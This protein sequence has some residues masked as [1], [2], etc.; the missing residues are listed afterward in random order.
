MFI[1]GYAYQLGHV[2]IG[3]EAIEQAIELNGAAVEMSRNAFRFGRLA[4]REPG[5]VARLMGTDTT[6][7]PKPQ[8]LEDIIAFRAEQLTQYQDAALAQRYRS[9]VE[10]MA[11]IERKLAPGR[12]GLAE[13]VARSY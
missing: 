4:A 13:A 10:Q 9:R 6:T 12:S 11:E 2:P 3:S 7:P 5:A 1:L 8:T